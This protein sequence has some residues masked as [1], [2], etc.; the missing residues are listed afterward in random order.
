VAQRELALILSA[1]VFDVLM[2]DGVHN[3]KQGVVRL[4]FGEASSTYDHG[5]LENKSRRVELRR[6]I[7][8]NEDERERRE[9]LS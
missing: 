7:R 3:G 4:P 9:Y 5:D 6:R 2:I 1:N 8:G